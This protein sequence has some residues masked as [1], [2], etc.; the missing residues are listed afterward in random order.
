VTYF[1]FYRTTL[2]DSRIFEA[3]FVVTNEPLYLDIYNFVLC[4][5]VSNFLALKSA[6]I[7]VGDIFEVM[8]SKWMESSVY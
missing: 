6:N 8:F 7:T 3:V 1:V 2:A 5:I 4:E